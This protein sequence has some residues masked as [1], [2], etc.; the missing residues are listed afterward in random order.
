MYLVMPRERSAT[1]AFMEHMTALGFQ[2][3]ITEFTEERY[4]APPM[5]DLEQGRK[6]FPEL[7]IRHFLLHKISRVA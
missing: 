7:R 6:E 2:E 3:E 5:R 4:L 1:P